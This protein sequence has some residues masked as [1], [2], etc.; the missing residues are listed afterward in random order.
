M[1]VTEDVTLSVYTVVKQFADS[2]G[3]D[4]VATTSIESASTIL[5]DGDDKIILVQHSLKDSTFIDLEYK[6]FIS[7]A[8][9]IESNA[10]K[11][12]EI[13]SNFISQF[14]RYSK[15]CIYEASGLK[16]VPSTYIDTGKAVV[17][18]DIGQE[19]IS[20]T[21]MRNNLNSITFK[22]LGYIK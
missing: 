4:F 11:T 19:I 16:E 22:L 7:F 6:V 1:A 8:E 5:M 14:P 13:M 21:Q 15:I 10:I 12:T 9:T 17:V 2:I 20:I 18:K 3:F